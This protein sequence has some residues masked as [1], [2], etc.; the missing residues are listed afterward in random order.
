[1][2]TTTHDIGRPVFGGLTNTL[3]YFLTFALLFMV[4]TIFG[5]LATSQGSKT[6][7]RGQ[8]QTAMEVYY[9]T[10]LKVAEVQI[11]AETTGA[12]AVGGGV[13]GGVIGSTIGRGRGRTLATAA[14]A[15]A[16]AAAG[17][18]AEKSGG[19]R[20]AL[21]IEVELDDGRLMVIV[22]EKDDEFAV[23]DRVR[24]LKSPDG[25]MRVRQ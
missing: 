22:Q 23:G 18:A 9:G 17:S 1:M 15:L 11:E 5:C 10:I 2:K 8:A 25:K 20:P 3:R 13:A 16:G 14:G 12:G 24:L 21:E 7:T 6:Y 4:S 19:T